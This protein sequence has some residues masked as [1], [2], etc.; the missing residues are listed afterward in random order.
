M[1]FNDEQKMVL[2]DNHF[3]T[4]ITDKQLSAVIKHCDASTLSDAELIGSIKAFR[5]LYLAGFPSISDKDYDTIFLE[6]QKKRKL[7]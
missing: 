2:D 3:L 6:E 5:V 4:G 1:R 7:N